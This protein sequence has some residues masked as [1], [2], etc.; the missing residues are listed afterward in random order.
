MKTKLKEKSLA[1]K[2]EAPDLVTGR[3]PEALIQEISLRAYQIWQE[4]G[5]THGFDQRDWLQAEQ[6][7]ILKYC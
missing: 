1:D 5:C 3:H 7:L 4:R 6:E 2:L